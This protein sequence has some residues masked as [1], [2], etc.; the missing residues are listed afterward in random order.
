MHD[1]SSLR[2][3]I[4]LEGSSSLCRT[5]QSR[6][7][8][9]ALRSDPWLS[10]GLGQYVLFSNRCLCGPTP[11]RRFETTIKREL[12]GMSSN[13]RLSALA[14]YCISRD[15]FLFRRTRI[16]EALA[17]LPDQ[18]KFNQ[19]LVPTILSDSRLPKELFLSAPPF[20]RDL[21]LERFLGVGWSSFV[22]PGFAIPLHGLTTNSSRRKNDAA[23][24][25]AAAGMVRIHAKTMCVAIVHRTARTR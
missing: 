10:Q 9:T 5:S 25:A 12:S 23:A 13:R 11:G 16:L 18:T 1:C 22:S 6:H 2:S 3:S 17:E 21:C 15:L 19:S 7:L 20:T 14:P 8:P 24:T 4:V